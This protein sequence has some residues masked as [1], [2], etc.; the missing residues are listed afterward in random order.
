[1]TVTLRPTDW[2]DLRVI[3]KN[4]SKGLYLDTA[5][6][7]TRGGSF[8]AGVLRSF[9]LSATNAFTWICTDECEQ[10]VL[11]QF[12]HIPG[13][14]FARLI[15]LAPDEALESDITVDL[16]EG[17]ARQAGEHGAFHLIAE[18][19]EESSA[20]E[21]MRKAGFVVYARQRVWKLQENGEGYKVAIPWITAAK[22]KINAAQSL[23]HNL[24]PGLVQQIEPLP[25]R[26]VG[27]LVC[28]EKGELLG[29]VDLK[30]GP[31][32][33]WAQPFIHPD[34]VDVDSRLRDMFECIPNR[35]SR[36]VFLCVRSYQSWLESA[37]NTMEARPG[38]Q[39][40]VMVKHL[41]A[42]HTV[43]RP[44]TLPQ[45]DGQPEIT[46]PVANSQQNS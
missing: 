14:P 34:T 23:Y 43:L 33:I 12:A 25:S 1:M 2:R 36:P 30:S 4:R 5:R 42:K 29:Y 11:G 16:L 28:H 15:L 38:P 21:S 31:R 45:L 44:F 32:G 8:A 19:P 13:N 3:H 37:L 39:Q 46:T 26:N 7:L 9:F 27:G 10:P 6:V 41:A 40:A 22:E 20:F 24:V 17:L 18:I 35:R